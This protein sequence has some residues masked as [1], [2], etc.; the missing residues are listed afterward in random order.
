M[1]IR[2]AEEALRR[3]FAEGWDVRVQLPVALDEDSEPEPDVSIVRRTDAASD[4]SHP[5]TASLVF[6]VAGESLQKDRLTKSALY[7]EAG[8]PEYVIVNVDQQCLEVH[9]DPDPASRRY[10]TLATLAGDQGFESSAVPG[11]AFRVASLFE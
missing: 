4:T 2:M 7:A 5:T 9:R 1:G 10:R 8:I 3:V 6:E 11:F